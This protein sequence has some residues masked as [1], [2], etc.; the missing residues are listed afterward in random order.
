MKAETVAGQNHKRQ[1]WIRRSPCS[2]AGS[3]C[4]SLR[5]TALMVSATEQQAAAHNHLL[6]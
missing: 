4:R 2:R 1:C 5:L 6:T 3:R